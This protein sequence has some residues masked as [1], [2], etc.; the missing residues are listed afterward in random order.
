[1]T[2]PPVK[3]PLLTHLVHGVRVFGAACC[4]THVGAEFDIACFGLNRS[5]LAAYHR[6]SEAVVGVVE[7]LGL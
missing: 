6:K 3:P 7:V 4:G 2:L 5:E 1:M